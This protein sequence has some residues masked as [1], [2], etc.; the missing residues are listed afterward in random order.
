MDNSCLSDMDR[1]KGN[2]TISLDPDIFMGILEIY[3]T[4]TAL[5]FA[6]Y[7]SHFMSER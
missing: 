5:K 3:K 6:V 1:G 4:V 7:Y 2:Q